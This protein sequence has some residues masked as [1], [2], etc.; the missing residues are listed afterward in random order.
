M[1]E[2]MATIL[3]IEDERDLAELVAFHLRQEGYTC[4]ICGDGSS[5]LAAALSAPP[6]LVVLDVMLPQLLGTEV[7]RELRREA[8]T[9]QVPVLMLTARGE[10]S[11]RVVGFEIGADDYL[12]KPFSVRELV[13]RIKALLRRSA[14]AA[15][16]TPQGLQIGELNIDTDRHEV[17]V[18]GAAVTLTSTE[19]RLLL[20]LAE[21]RG[22]LQSRDTLLQDVWGYHYV[23]DT[24]TVDTHITRLRNKLGAAGDLIQ[25]VRGFGYKLEE[26]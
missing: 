18:A 12:T 2:T 26:P 7:C 24:R 4:Q 3:I 11:D 22:R 17:T 13:L 6:D 25:T 14:P 1:A 19:Y 20:T 23:G 5:G 16:D 15:T 21:R 10:E 9:R 8:R